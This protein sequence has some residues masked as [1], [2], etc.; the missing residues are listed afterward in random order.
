VNHCQVLDAPTTRLVAGNFPVR[1]GPKTGFRSPAGGVGINLAIQDA[2]ATANLLTGALR[3]RRVTEALLARVQCRREFPTRATQLLQVQAHKLFAR[4]FQN[5]GPVEVPWQLKVAVNIPFVNDL[6][7]RVVGNGFR[8]E[9]IAGTRPRQTCSAICL[10]KVAVGIGLVA[11]GAT[12]TFRRFTRVR[13]P[14]WA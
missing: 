4:I 6:L 3:N 11:A 14:G 7:G 13:R 9:H 1:E 10:K 5:P 8:P 2:V 12:L